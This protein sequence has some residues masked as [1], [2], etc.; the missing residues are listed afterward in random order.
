MEFGIKMSQKL[1]KYALI[2]ISVMAFIATYALLAESVDYGN[3]KALDLAFMAAGIFIALLTYNWLKD[4]S[5]VRNDNSTMWKYWFIGIALYVIFM[6]IIAN[7]PKESLLG[8]IS[9]ILAGCMGWF[10]YLKYHHDM[11]GSDNSF[12]KKEARLN[13]NYPI[14][15]NF[16]YRL[17]SKSYAQTLLSKKYLY[18][19]DED[20]SLAWAKKAYKSSDAYVDGY[21]IV[22]LKK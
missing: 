17:L 19:K 3:R 6:L 7:Q 10:G 5:L 8:A 13:S 18:E 16:L 12:C 9:L 22:R 14:S 4:K 20:K 21:T 2:I 15:N 1:K 11:I